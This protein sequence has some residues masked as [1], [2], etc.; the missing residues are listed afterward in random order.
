MSVS[1]IYIY[2]KYTQ[3]NTYILKTKTFILDAINII[4]Q[5]STKYN[6]INACLS[7]YLW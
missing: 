1:Y 6:V 5:Y 3:Y 7:V 2:N 4:I